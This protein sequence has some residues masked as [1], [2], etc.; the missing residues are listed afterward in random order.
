MKQLRTYLF[1]ISLLVTGIVLCQEETNISA[2]DTLPPAEKYGLRVGVDIGRFI[3]TAVND[4][5]TGFEI[6]AD[7]RVY[8]NYYFAGEIGNESF[9][10]DETN[11]E[12]EGAGSYIRLGFDYNTYK[13]WY[14]MQNNIYVGL[15]YGFAN[16]N[17]T[18]EKY[19]IFTGTDFFGEDER[20]EKIEAKSLTAGWVEFILGIKVETLKNLYLG[21]NVSLRR[22]VNEKTPEGFDNL[23]I[24]GYGRTNDFS[25][26]GV[27]Y[28]YTISYLIPF[29]KRKR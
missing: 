17:Q 29:A 21:A 24:P 7:Y 19:N 15:R 26:F 27:G 8:K 5:Y 13:N 1:F 16:F 9:L 23:F 3:R 28:T 4:D 25:L 12:V 18:L 6:N 20:N 2:R 14:G 11:I 22:I 10:R